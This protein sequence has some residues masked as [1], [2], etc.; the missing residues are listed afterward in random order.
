VAKELF[1][2][3]DPVGNSILIGQNRFEVIAVLQEKGE[4]FGNDQD[5]IIIIPISAYIKF[6]SDRS[7]SVEKNR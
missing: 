4:L 6:F 2:F 3:V 7:V 5:N 1:G